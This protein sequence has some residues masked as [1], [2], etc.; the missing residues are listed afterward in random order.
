MWLKKLL[1]RIKKNRVAPINFFL[2]QAI[3]QA[4]FRPLAHVRSGEPQY[5]KVC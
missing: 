3:F 4:W 5:V 1:A 2:S